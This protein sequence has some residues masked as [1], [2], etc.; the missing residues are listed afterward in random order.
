MQNAP[1]PMVRLLVHAIWDSRAMEQFAKM[2]M[3]AL[4]TQPIIVT[5]GWEAVRIQRDRLRVSV[6]LLR[7]EQW[8]GHMRMLME[9]GPTV[10]TEMSA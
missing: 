2:W 9:M 6:I 5:V 4:A 3:S 7:S 8:L 1:V 10:E